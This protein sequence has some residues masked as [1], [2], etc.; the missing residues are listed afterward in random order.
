MTLRRTMVTA[1]LLSMPGLGRSAGWL[2]QQTLTIGK[3]YLDHLF[4]KADG[5]APRLVAWNR[6]QLPIFLRAFIIFCVCTSPSLAQSPDRN[7]NTEPP[8]A[9]GGLYIS[10]ARG[11]QD[12]S[13][14]IEEA[15]NQELGVVQH[16]TNLRRQGSDWTLNITT[17]FPVG[18]QVHQL[19]YTLPYLFLRG[20]GERAN[21]IGDI[22]LN[23]RYQ[24]VA[25][26]E[27]MPAF[28]P[29]LSLIL[30]TGRMRMG[31]GNS[32]FGL[33]GSLP[34]SK[35]VGDRM[36]L[37]ANTGVTSLFDV[38]D[39]SLTSLYL[40]GSVVY[41]ASRNFNLLF[42]AVG[43]R[44]EKLNEAR[45][46]ER[47][48]GLTF[49]PGVRYAFDLPDLQIVLGLGAPVTLTRGERPSFGAIFYLSFEGQVAN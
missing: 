25:E 16:I 41:A 14:L 17:E 11:I 5:L 31:V 35:V 18:G 45:R 19:S 3:I 24:A 15:Y 10:P 49:S 38:Q 20:A 46:I 47:E 1:A 6:E 2:V 29:R 43:E 42:E 23:Y 34:L 48:Y 27:F 39:R 12:N 26:S 9:G 21:G 22:L 44:M 33:Q 28:A 30:P 40:G 36:T 32:S 7:V 13:L 8:T 37:H 4:D